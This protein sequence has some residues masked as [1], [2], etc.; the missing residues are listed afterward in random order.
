VKVSSLG[1]II[2]TLP[3]VTDAKRAYPKLVFDWV[4]EENFTEVP[5]WH[6][7]VDRVIPVAIR[8]WRKSLMRTYLTHEFRAFKRA[9][10][11]TRYDLVIDAQGLI[12]SG[13]ISRMSRGLTIGL[14]N[15]TVREPLAAL[16]YNKAYSIPWTEHAVD[17]V[18]QLF[19]RA[20]QYQYDTDLISYGIDRAKLKTKTENVPG[21]TVVFLHGTTRENKYWPEE[22][23]RNLAN[24]ATEYGYDVVLPWGTLEEKKR[25]EFIGEGNLNVKILGKKSL[26]DLAGVIIKSKGVIAVDTGLGHLAAALSKSTV[27]L[28][29]PTNPALCGT[30][31]RNQVH[32][33]LEDEPTDVWNKFEKLTNSL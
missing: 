26:S 18:R 8:R 33:K 30:Y 31:G 32:S 19:S 20:L 24:L 17:R 22:K 27:S 13:I 23:W 29:G 6:P 7:A 11:G 10:Q 25:A 28:Y 21:K 2:H 5:A 1:D 14:S 9:L 4:V 12:K 3:A 15:R 16:F